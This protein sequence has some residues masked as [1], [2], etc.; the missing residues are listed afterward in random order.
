MDMGGAAAALGIK[1]GFSDT[2]RFVDASILN[3]AL[4]QGV[5]PVGVERQIA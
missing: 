2:S 5:D 4:R 3:H 1:K